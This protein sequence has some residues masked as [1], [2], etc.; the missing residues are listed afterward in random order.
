MSVDGVRRTMQRVEFWSAD[1]TED[2]RG[3]SARRPDDLRLQ[4]VSECGV[5]R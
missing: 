3:G 1:P 5:N 2:E 4:A